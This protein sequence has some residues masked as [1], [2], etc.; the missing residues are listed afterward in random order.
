V[1]YESSSR[2]QQLEMLIADSIGTHPLL[3]G[4]MVTIEAND[5]IVTLTGVVRSESSRYLADLLAR[6]NGA[7][8]VDNRLRVETDGA[9]QEP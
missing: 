7:L 2:D 4:A 5:S 3:W 6:T 9:G 1:P 8:N